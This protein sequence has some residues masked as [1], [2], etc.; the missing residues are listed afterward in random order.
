MDSAETACRRNAADGDRD[1][2]RGFLVAGPPEWRERGLRTRPRVDTLVTASFVPLAIKARGGL[3]PAALRRV[4]DYVESHLDQTI[5][6]E[7]LAA[8]AGLSTYHFARAFKQSE[9]TTPHGFVLER[10]IAKAQELLRRR[11]LTLSEIA[12]ATGF[13]DQSHF[14]RRFREVVGMAPGQFRKSRA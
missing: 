12:I 4:R 6:V 10:R 5:E 1:P 2:A 14:T 9:A 11:D 8:A 3:T 7:S 13:A